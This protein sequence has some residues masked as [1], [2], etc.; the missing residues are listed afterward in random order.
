M[1]EENSMIEI[2]NDSRL[3]RLIAAQAR[4]ERVDSDQAEQAAR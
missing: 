2:R 1:K 3:V 4:G